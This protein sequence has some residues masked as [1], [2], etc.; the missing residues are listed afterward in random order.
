MIEQQRKENFFYLLRRGDTIK[1]I[2]GA[3]KGKLG[4][5]IDVD[6]ANKTARVA[7]YTKNAE[8]GRLEEMPGLLDLEAD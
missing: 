3:D 7:L 8:T 2:L 4:K 5:V 1:V 6:K